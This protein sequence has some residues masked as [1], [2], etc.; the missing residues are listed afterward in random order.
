MFAAFARGDLGIGQ[1]RDQAFARGHIVHRHAQVA[2]GI[3]AAERAILGAGTEIDAPWLQAV[4]NGNGIDRAAL[5]GQRLCHAEV[6][7]EIPTGGGN[8]RGAPVE[9]FGG[10]RRRIGGIDHQARQ[11]LLGKA[12]RQRH[13]D[14]ATA[15]D[16][17][18]AR[19]SLVRG[20][21][22][23]PI[24][25]HV[26]HHFTPQVLPGPDRDRGSDRHRRLAAP[27]N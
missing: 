26:A 3:H 13:A 27:A 22:R 17:D 19:Q 8:G 18:V 4:G 7:V 10:L 15:E 25:R 23:R 2:V 12:D 14:Q 24:H 6:G 21:F 16:H 1:E 11:A 9:A 20:L 5:G